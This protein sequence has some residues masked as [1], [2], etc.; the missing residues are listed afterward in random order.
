M[1]AL[2]RL[3]K[4]AEGDTGGSRRAAQFLLSLW[5]GDHYQAD[6]QAL[7]YVD[8]DMH[9]D[10]VEVFTYRYTNN[11]QLESL[12]TESD[13]QTVIFSWGPVF[14]PD[15]WPQEDRREHPIQRTC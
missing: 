7:L 6:L 12:V 15:L 8:G 10:R 11:D 9:R 4:Y 1:D 14:R 3:I 2:E 5:N 13:L